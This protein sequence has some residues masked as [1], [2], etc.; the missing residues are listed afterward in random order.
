MGI[1]EES[2]LPTFR[3]CS[4]LRQTPSG[5]QALR[6]RAGAAGNRRPFFLPPN[7]PPERVEA[8]R[9]AFDATVKDPAFLA[10]AD[11]SK[12]EVDPLTGEQ[13]AAL[14]EQVS[15]TPADTVARVRAAMENK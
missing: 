12:I 8:L 4:I 15:H 7:V 5:R 6:A 3:W 1:E 2:S 11:K 13:V 10:D 9:R 14:V